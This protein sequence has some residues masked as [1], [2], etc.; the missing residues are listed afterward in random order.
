MASAKKRKPE[1]KSGDF[2][3]KLQEEGWQPLRWQG[4]TLLF[5]R[6]SDGH[7]LAVKWQKEGETPDALQREL[8]TVNLLREYKE[9]L[10]L[11]SRFPEPVGIFEFSGEL[12]EKYYSSPTVNVEAKKEGAKRIAYVYEF[13]DEG[14]FIYPNNPLLSRE[15][16]QNV[17]RISY[18]DL[19]KL[20]SDDIIMIAL[21]DLFHNNEPGHEARED[22]G[23]FI[24]LVGLVRSYFFGEGAGRLSR[25]FKAIEFPNIGL[26]GIRDVGD[27]ELLDH[28]SKKTHPITSKNFSNLFEESKRITTHPRADLVLRANFLAEYLQVDELIV[29]ARA[30]EENHLNWRSTVKVAKTAELLK[31]GSKALFSSYTGM[32]REA[33]D[34]FIDQSG[35]N[36]DHYGKQMGFWMQNNRSGYLPYLKKKVLP[37]GLY[38][39]GVETS[40]SGELRGMSQEIGFAIDG[41]NPDLGTV[42][43]PYPITEGVKNRYLT[44]AYMLLM[45][46]VAALTNT[47]SA[48]NINRKHLLQRI[49]HLNPKFLNQ[50]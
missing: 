10:Q 6:E 39:E 18:H 24:P 34:P 14:Y 37:K 1:I 16:F 41:V 7:F 12:L 50:R 38:S 46:E 45:R 43:G 47:L 19:G 28:L 25:F 22:A 26:S 36:W 13:P 42:N 17:R 29:G 49:L 4:R 11:K 20:A 32:D 15:E 21:A 33:V 40:F 30:K 35:V 31:E 2:F 8:E 5:K 23:R 44:I 9:E 3:H 27:S 48:Q